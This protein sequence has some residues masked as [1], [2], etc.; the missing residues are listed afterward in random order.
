[1]LVLKYIRC[2]S[3]LCDVNYTWGQAV[4]ETCYSIDYL[5]IRISFMTRNYF[6]SATYVIIIDWIGPWVGMLERYCQ[7]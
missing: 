6:R 7:I 5:E 2:L 4:C 3:T 1:V